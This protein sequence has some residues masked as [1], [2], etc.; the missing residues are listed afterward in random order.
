MIRH[1]ASTWQDNP[2]D[3]VLGLT[4][5]EAITVVIKESRL[6]YHGY[7]HTGDGTKP[8]SL[9]CMTFDSDLSRLLVE[10]SKEFKR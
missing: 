10:L 7:A 6:G 3:T 8:G 1:A 4:P 5:R 2:G 9:L